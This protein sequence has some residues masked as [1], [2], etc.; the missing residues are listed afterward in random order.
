MKTIR[1]EYTRTWEYSKDHGVYFE[2]SNDPSKRILLSKDFDYPRTW[3]IYFMISGYISDAETESLIKKITNFIKKDEYLTSSG[4]FTNSD[5][6]WFDKFIG[7]WEDTGMI[8]VLTNKDTGE[9][10]YLPILKKK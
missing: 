9:K 7:P 10:I 6:N 3:N 4:Y 5:K 8:R 2:L 1:S